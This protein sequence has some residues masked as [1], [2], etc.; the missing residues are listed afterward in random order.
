MEEKK[1]IQ[2]PSDCLDLLKG[3][4]KKKQEHFGVILLD[5]AHQVITKR[6]LFKGG[7]NKS[8]VD[9]KVVFHTACKVAGACAVILYH[10]HPSGHVVPSKEDIETT[11]DLNEG[12]NLLGFQLLDHIIVGGNYNYYSFLENDGMF[13]TE[14][15]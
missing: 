13:K 5:G 14:N 7:F 11:L 9:K 4:L 1:V 2:K 15:N 12:F 10:N 3:L 8:V 6:D